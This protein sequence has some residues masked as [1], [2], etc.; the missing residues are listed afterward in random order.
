MI[1]SMS[2]PAESGGVHFVEIAEEGAGQRIDN[3]LLT[4]LKGAPRSLVYRILRKGE[5]RVNRGRIGP[6]YRLQAGDNVRIPPVRLTERTAAVPPGEAVLRRIEAAIIYEDSRFL[7]LNKPGGV[8]V[9]GGSG[10]NYGV[11]EALR[12]SR[13]EAPFLELGHRLDRETSGCLVIAKRRSALRQ[14]HALLREGRVVKRYLAL[15]AGHWTGLL[16]MELALRKNVLRSGERLVRVAED[17]KSAK[18]E[19]RVARRFQE[20]TLAEVLLFTGRTHQV[21]VHAAAAG[22]PIAGDEKYGDEAFNRRMRALGLRRLFLHAHSLRFEIP[23]NGSRIE[24]SAPLDP[25]LEAVLATL[26]DYE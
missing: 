14:F 5:V 1:A 15:L 25:A 6:D 19:F 20:A 8:A 26:D 24:V 4:R 22:H 10:L 21:R 13:P 12:A 9:H 3:F 11:I 16:R 2:K 17:G 7:V 18:T 23:E